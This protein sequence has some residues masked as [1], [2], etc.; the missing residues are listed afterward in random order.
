MRNIFKLIVL[1]TAII[2]IVGCSK[3]KPFTPEVVTDKTYIDVTKRG[4]DYRGGEITINVESN[5]YWVINFDEEA[6][7]WLKISPKASTGSGVVTITVYP[8]DG[9]A[10]SAELT[11][12]TSEGE[13]TS[14]TIAQGAVDEVLKFYSE[15]FGSEEVTDT[16]IYDFNGWNTDGIG[17]DMVAYSGTAKVSS[18]KPSHGYE[19]ASG[20]NAIC[21]QED[22]NV[23][24]YGPVLVGTDEYFNLSF[25]VG[26][27]AGANPSEELKVEASTDGEAWFPYYYTQV[28]GTQEWELSSTYFRVVEIDRIYFRIT[29]PEGYAVDDFVIREADPL[30]CHYE[31]EFGYPGDDNHK[32]GYCYFSDYFDWVTYEYGGSDYIANPAVNTT[33]TRFDIVYTLAPELVQRF[34]E[35]G[36]LQTDNE[37]PCYLRLGYLK[38]GRS[39][40]QGLLTS[41]ALTSIREGREVNVQLSYKVTGYATSAGLEDMSGIVIEVEGGGT[42]NSATK[43][44]VEM[45][46]EEFNRWP[47]EPSVVTIYNATHNT[48]IIFRSVYS[49]ATLS[50]LN[51][52]SRF[53]LDEVDVVKISKI[54]PVVEDWQTILEIPVLEESSVA[55]GAS[56]LTASW[57]AINHAFAYEY[58][59]TD[60]DHKFVTSGTVN[61][62]TCSINGLKVGYYYNLK[63]R[64]V[65]H[66]ESLRY[67]ASDWSQEVTVQTIDKDTHEI[68]YVFFSD[69]FDWIDARYGIKVDGFTDGFKDQECKGITVANGFP[70]ETVTDWATHGWTYK[71][72]VY[73]NFGTLKIGRT[74][75]ASKNVGDHAGEFYMP[76]GCV[77]EITQDATVNVK[78]EMDITCVTSLNDTKSYKISCSNGESYTRTFEA[79][80]IREWQAIEPIIFHNVTNKA[81]FTISTMQ[82]QQEIV[83]NRIAIDNI[84]ISKAD[85]NIE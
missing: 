20:G 67:V 23:F 83:P 30:L 85:P 65:P 11:F 78:F 24:N 52:S 58:E 82:M 68:G 1:L 42:I 5:T 38:M 60:A 59:V 19:G 80:A 66:Q 7:D 17:S 28:S 47:D 2:S 37:R 69:N 55:T 35:A 79:S 8:N 72:R 21:F 26:L 6:I 76:A 84:K 36:W 49:T 15:D 64:A 16:S 27:P 13:K 10:R 18:T 44:A 40:A 71:G 33:E 46:V 81:T 4:L 34:E 77:S 56:S 3:E 9:E 12:D 43:T 51:K 74:V 57:P 39:K 22:A 61:E 31:V 14:V 50:S 75:S 73:V 29:A 41:P 63:V 70:Q 32:I 25:G 45:P 53:F 54:T 62:P 48:R